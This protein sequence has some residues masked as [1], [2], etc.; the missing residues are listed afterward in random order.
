MLWDG[1]A[2]RVSSLDQNDVASV[3]PV[4]N[5][6]SALKSSN[7]SLARKRGQRWHLR[8]NLDLADLDCRRHPMGCTR[9]QAACYGFADVLQRFGFRASLGN[10]SWNRWTFRNQHARLVLF[11]RNEKLHT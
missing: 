3:L 8:G 2:C 4:L 9:G 11:E 6:A 5:P 1:Q 7:R 10:A